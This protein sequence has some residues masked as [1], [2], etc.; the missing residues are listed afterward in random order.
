[1]VIV[2]GVRQPENAILLIDSTSVVAKSPML[3]TE[4]GDLAEKLTLKE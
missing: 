3:S 2:D 1:M 4:S